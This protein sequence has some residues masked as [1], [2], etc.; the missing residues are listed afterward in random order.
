MDWVKDNISRRELDVEPEARRSAYLAP[1]LEKGLDVLELLAGVPEGLTQSQI[2]QRCN[3][4]LQEVYR[5]VVSLERRGYIT[6]WPQ[7][8][9]FRLTMKL[10]DLALTFPPIARLT[11]AAPPIMRRLSLEVEQSIL[12]SVIDGATIRSI[13]HIDS[14]APIG[15]RVRLGVARPVARTASGRVLL[16]FQPSATQKW[17]FEAMAQSGVSAAELKR[18]RRRVEAIAQAGYEFI[19]GETFEG[20]TDVS[21]PVIDRKGEVLAA[22][23]MP[24]LRSVADKVDIQR[25]AAAQFE[26]AA[27]LSS[28]FGGELHAPRSPLSD[29][30]ARTAST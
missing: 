15:F 30:L 13:A 1:A 3:R 20:I 11:D 6:R 10:Y 2:A 25:A 18:V 29:P 4:S 9:V 27:E 21:F 28:I 12:L 16:A 23:T 5:M 8:D 26:A 7:G 14:P 24:F 19:S 17:I 22:L